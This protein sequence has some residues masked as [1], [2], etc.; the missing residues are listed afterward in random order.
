MMNKTTFKRNDDQNVITRMPN[1]LLFRITTEGLYL[2]F[3][4]SGYR[5]VYYGRKPFDT[6]Y[7]VQY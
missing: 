7:K 5:L 2:L 1:I 6:F 3:S 4:V